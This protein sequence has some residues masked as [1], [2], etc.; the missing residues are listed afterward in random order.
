M[1]WQKDVSFSDMT[2]KLI[3]LKTMLGLPDARTF[4]TALHF[5]NYAD[6]AE[7]AG[8]SLPANNT[9][10]YSKFVAIFHGR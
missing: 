6:I 7:S 1:Y 10:D 2:G 5:G 8:P 9:A 3:D 4:K